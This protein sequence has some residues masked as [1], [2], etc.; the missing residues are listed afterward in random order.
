MALTITIPD[1]DVQLT[2][3]A[4][5]VEIAGGSA[6]GGSEEYKLL[7]KIIST[8]SKLF[9]GPFI[10]AITPDSTGKSVFDIS[11]YVDQ[12]VTAV[13]QWPL[14]G[15]VKDYAT[16]AFNISLE[17]G[18]RYIDSNDDLVETWSGVTDT[19][20]LLKGG[21]SPRQVAALRDA[22]SNF[23]EKYILGGKWLT[24][25]PW[26]DFVHPT[27][28]V[29]MWFLPASEATTN[30]RVKG[31]YNDGSTDTADTEVTLDPDKLY[32]FN[33][34]PAQNGLELEPTG[35]RMTHFDVSLVNE[36]E[37]RRFSFDWRY[38]E[39]PV[40]L[41]FANTFGGVDDVFFS[42]TLKDG[43]VT[44]GEI[45]ERTPQQTDTVF[46]PTLLNLSRTGQNK[47]VVNTGFK[48]IPTLQFYRD[49]LVSKQAWYLYRN[50][51]QTSTNVIPVIIDPADI[52][53]FD[54]GN[55]LYEMEISFSE[56]HVSR[57]SFDNRIF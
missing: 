18:E 19:M 56:A 50:I 5:R 28:P 7:L 41:L 22:G 12:P 26:G 6:P 16:Q 45:S 1:G 3:N 48:D 14:S 15:V 27:Q 38:C 36:S 11:G 4:V 54:R 57:H 53:L 49:L 52:T 40:F 8:D 47:W 13:F 30:F 39:R 17:A 43:F 46:T 2:G 42:G 32:E 9:G 25:R 20:Q 44:Q 51:T 33:C 37:T 55:D 29:K 34:N 23:Y 31:Y 35:K 10:D 24:A 21:I